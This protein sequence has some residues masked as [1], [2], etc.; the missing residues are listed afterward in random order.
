MGWHELRNVT[1]EVI[2]EVGVV[3]HGAIS[4]TQNKG[5]HLTT[6]RSPS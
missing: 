6:V 1:Q 2:G 3:V 4:L 5:R